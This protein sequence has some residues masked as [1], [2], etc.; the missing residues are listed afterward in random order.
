MVE[1][2]YDYLPQKHKIDF[3]TIL[4]VD[5]L[6]LEN[7]VLFYPIKSEELKNY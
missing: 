7:H 5:G 1:R 2:Y 4:E 3:K 6:S